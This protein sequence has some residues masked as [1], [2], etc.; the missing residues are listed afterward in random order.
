[1]APP[2][3][4][5]AGGVRAEA[6]EAEMGKKIRRRGVVRHVRRVRPQGRAAVT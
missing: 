6:L 4:A 1:M 3:E 5:G 2:T